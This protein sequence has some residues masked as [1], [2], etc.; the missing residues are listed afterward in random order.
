MFKQLQHFAT[1]WSNKG[2]LIKFIEKIQN[3]RLRSLCC[4]FMDFPVWVKLYWK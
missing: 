2:K 1:I 4:C 3:Q